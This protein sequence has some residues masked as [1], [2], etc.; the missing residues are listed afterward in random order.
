MGWVNVL[1]RFTKVLA[2]PC[3]SKDREAAN[4]HSVAPHSLM[5]PPGFLS[6]G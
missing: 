4:G 2:V 1:T 5:S 6:I 3:G